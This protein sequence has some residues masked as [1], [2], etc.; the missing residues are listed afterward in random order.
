[1]LFV[2]SRKLDIWRNPRDRAL[3]NGLTPRA[4]PYLCFEEANY[5]SRNLARAPDLSNI[6]SMYMVETVFRSNLADIVSPLRFLIMEC[7]A[8]AWPMC[9]RSCVFCFVESDRCSLLSHL[10]VHVY[11]ND[12]VS[13]I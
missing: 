7:K 10:W 8:E 13:R 6:V 12:L 1:M 11:Y 5:R 3:E 4:M 9:A 2:E